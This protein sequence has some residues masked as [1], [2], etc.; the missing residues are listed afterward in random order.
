VRAFR[1]CADALPD[2]AR[3]E[4]PRPAFALAPE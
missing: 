3:R 2:G 1:E 4:P